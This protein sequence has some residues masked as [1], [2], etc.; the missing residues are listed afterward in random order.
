MDSEEE[1][2]EDE[3]EEEDGG[4][5]SKDEAD[6]REEPAPAAGYSRSSSVDRLSSVEENNPDGA[7][8]EV[9][10]VSRRGTLRAVKQ[11]DRLRIEEDDERWAWSSPFSG[12]QSSSYSLPPPLPPSA[13]PPPILPHL[14]VIDTSMA[15]TLRKGWL[16]LRGKSNN[17]WNKHWVVL[18]GL[19]LKLFK[20]RLFLSR[21]FYLFR[22]TVT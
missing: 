5:G 1:E 13:P 12:Q 18:A 17:E 4:Q 15:H 16:M 22:F 21:V 6:G 20:V 19:S 8:S 10:S 9:S 2:D 7:G 3:E 14:P 11:R